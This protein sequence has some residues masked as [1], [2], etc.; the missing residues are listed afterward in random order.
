MTDK[1]KKIF[2]VFLMAFECLLVLPFQKAQALYGVDLGNL[3]GNVV[4]TAMDQAFSKLGVDQ[5][6]LKYT[7]QSMNVSRRKKQQPQ[8]EMSF[9]PANPVTAQKVTAVATP[10]NFLN[11][12]EN[13]YFTWYLKPD[14][15]PDKESSPSGT[16]KNKCDFDGDGKIS[17]NDYK[18]KAMRIIANDDFEWDKADYGS[19]SAGKSYSA[20][21]GG[22]DQKGKSNHCFVHD[23]DSGDEYEIE[24][25][26]HLFPED[27][28][29]N[30]DI[31]DGSFGL[32]EEKFWH[33]DPNDP[34]TADTGNGDEAN[35]AGLGMDTFSWVYEEGDEVGVVIEGI[36]TESTQNA[37]SSFKIM[38]AF[39]NN[40]CDLGSAD[41]DGYP[42]TSTS[43]STSLSVG[44]TCPD[45]SSTTVQT[46]VTTTKSIISRIA[47]NAVVRTTTYSTD[48]TDSNC[49]G[50]YDEAAGA[51]YNQTTTGPNGPDY[52]GQYNGITC[53][54]FDEN[55]NLEDEG[56]SLSEITKVSDLNDCL[57]E[58]YINPTEGGEA[59]TKMD[60][61]LSYS[62]DFPMNDPPSGSSYDANGDGDKLS[63]QSTVT[64][65]D[66]PGYL[67]YT[68]QLYESD[69]PNPDSWGDPIS[70]SRLPDSLNLSG[71]GL[72]SLSFRLNIPDL[73]KYLK[74]KVTVTE[75]YSS[76]SEARTGHADVIIPISQITQ[77]IKVFS[78]S[79]SESLGLSLKSTERCLTDSTPDAI[80][81]VAK[82]EIIGLSVSK[83]GFSDFLWTANNEAIPPAGN[84]T[85]VENTAYLPILEDNGYQY[86]IEMIATNSDGEKTDLVRTLKVAD[87][88]VKIVSADESICK[89]N[90]LGYYIDTDGK[91]WSDYSETN[92][93]AL[94]GTDI[95]LEPE[96]DGVSPSVGDYFWIVD[97][98][99]ITSSNASSYG[100][101]VDSTSG[102]I[103][104]PG[105]SL[106]E[107]YDV[108]VSLV[109]TQDNN[110][111]KALNE[112][113][114]VQQNEFYEKK[115][116][117]TIEITF[118]G[119]IS[120]TEGANSNNSPKKILASIYSATPAYIAFLL[121]ITL[122]GFAM[123]IFSRIIL[124]FFPNLKENDPVVK[125]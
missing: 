51:A 93:S 15:C 29:N 76:G 23:I 17:I 113:W 43:H 60:V 77:R 35:V 64:N 18:V 7:I 28:D 66:N 116:G 33:T 117:K 63:L 75:N 109:Y 22:N 110:T 10:L 96:F 9:N 114:G 56:L 72:D 5:N 81:Y 19:G 62:P 53:T 112:Y 52:L 120:D 83:D 32:S 38:W 98:Y 16:I 2:L 115:V 121:R 86:S 42:K 8:I 14:G 31:G 68:W 90:L 57:D 4:G 30:W 20:I 74:V 39:V 21:W 118:V 26:K 124:S 55:I 71:I 111:K 25:N 103:T 48:T 27:P 49:D 50:V 44:E 97:G 85:K 65:A 123:I 59:K 102:A 3:S 88:E 106:G 6:E 99:K 79:V 67:K 58:N 125:F 78:A 105:K 94:S 70:K 119:S 37:D 54:G 104:L 1:T 47:N 100:Y 69:T 80:C 95:E 24:C 40:K 46:T 91:Y 73:E 89:A 87:P 34:D 61:S 84:Q 41:E 107:T 101:S 108:G 45:G 82:N 12:T 122:T 92:F 11:T 13:L 36:S